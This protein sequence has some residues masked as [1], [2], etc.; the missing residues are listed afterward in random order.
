MPV[1]KHG[2]RRSGAGR[3]AK[4]GE[5]KESLTL[6]V[7]P[8]LKEF[9]AAQDGSQSDF[10]EAALRRSAAFRRWSRSGNKSVEST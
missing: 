9:L 4:Y 10:V 7:T 1:K 6:S 8:T 2:G 3:P 5:T